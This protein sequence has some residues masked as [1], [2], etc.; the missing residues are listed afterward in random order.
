M[1]VLINGNTARSKELGDPFFWD[2]RRARGKG[3]SSV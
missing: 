3:V 1:T 2:A